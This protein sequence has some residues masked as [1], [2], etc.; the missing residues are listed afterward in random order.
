LK[1]Y[2]PSCVYINKIEKTEVSS[3]REETGLKPDFGR[4]EEKLMKLSPG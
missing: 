2:H 3:K 1:K 4:M